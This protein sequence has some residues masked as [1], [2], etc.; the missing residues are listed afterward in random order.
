MAIKVLPS[1]FTEDKE[2]LARFEREAQ[3]LAQLHHPNIASIFAMEKSGT[4]IDFLATRGHRIGGAAIETR[5]HLC[6]GHGAGR[7]PDLGGEAGVGFL[8]LD[9][10]LS[11]ARQIAEALEAAHEKGIVH[12]DLKPQNIKASIE[13]KVKVLDFGL[14][15]AMDPGG[16]ASGAAA[17]SQLAQSPTLTMGATM[18]GTILGTAAYMAPEQARGGAVD[19]RADIWAFGVVVYEMLSGETLFAEGSVVDTLSAVMRK[20]IDLAKLPGGVSPRLRELVRRCLERDPRRR[21]RDIGEARL[22]LESAL[23]GESGE[24]AVPVSGPAASPSSSGRRLAVA[25]AIAAA[26]LIGLV[27]GRVAPSSPALRAASAIRATIALPAGLELDGVGAPEIALS[28]DGST[29]AFLA[30]GESGPQH[31]YV[32]RLDSDEAKLV[33]DSATAEGPFFSPDGKWVAFAVGVSGLGGGIPQ[34]LRK[35]SLETGLTQTIA[36]IDDYFGGVWR[37]EARFS[38]SMRPMDRGLVGA[39][40]RRQAFGR[41][42]PGDRPRGTAR[43]GALLARAAAGATRCRSTSVLRPVASSSCSTSI[44]AS[45]PGS[46]CTACRRATCRPAISPSAAREERSRSCR[47]T[48]IG[49]K[50]SARRWRRS[51]TSRGRAIARRPMLLLL[52]WS[53]RPAT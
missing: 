49:G 48:P 5:P 38:S 32:R 15:K 45:S 1:A 17:V 51:P 36:P 11:L 3:L 21:L 37:Q 44:R 41:R 39:G 7:G 23:A 9:E 47:S 40:E 4:G 24:D 30:R 25:A 13:G 26:G 34:E 35:Q 6:A 29:L 33:P 14:A 50:S 16:S 10:S 22:L 42:R 46:A 52:R 12:R 27:V 53:M 31:L 8:P 19:K 28:P 20:E 43:S 18:Q 2:R